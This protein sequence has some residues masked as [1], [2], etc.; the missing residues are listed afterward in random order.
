MIF[1]ESRVNY[2]ILC[3]QK[4]DSAKE[5]DKKQ[6]LLLHACCAPCSSSVLEYLDGFFDITLFFYNPNISSKEEYDKRLNELK[7]LISEMELKSK[8]SVIDAI[9]DPERF[10]S[11]SKGLEQEKERGKRCAE[12]YY[13]RLDK[14]AE[15]AKNNGFDLFC[16][17]LSVSPHKDAFLINETG[18]KLEEK[19]GIEWLFSDFKKKDGYKRS[20]ELSKKYSLYRQNF[21][22][23]V[24]S[25]NLQNKT[26]ED[27]QK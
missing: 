13:L 23:C 14:T 27:D 1:T 12:C 25:Q 16:T 4:L 17:T 26:T 18:K 20:I 24:F 15:Y 2:G 9:Y 22:G 19:Y 7:R 10:Y 8:P 21:C 11:V 5:S 6:K 3:D